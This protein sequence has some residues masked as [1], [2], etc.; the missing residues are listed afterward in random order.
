MSAAPRQP[1]SSRWRASKPPKPAPTR[2]AGQRLTGALVDTSFSPCLSVVVPVRNDAVR[3]QR[4]L[5]ALAG[6][7]FRDFE[8]IVIDDASDDD[9][10]HVAEAM[11]AH[12]VRLPQQSGSAAARNAGAEAA[13]GQI[14]L[15]VDSDVLVRHDTLQVA[16]DA[17]HDPQV[18]AVFGSYDLEPQ[19]PNLLS[20]YKNLAHR[21]YHQAMRGRATTFWTGCGAIRRGVFRAAGGFDAQRFVR[22]TIEDIELGVR[23]TN[24]GHVISHDKQ[25]QVTHLKRWTLW[26]IIKSDVFDRA[27]PWTRLTA[28]TRHVPNNLNLAKSQ[29]ASAVLSGALLAIYLAACWYLPWLIIAPI[30]VFLCIALSDRWTTRHRVTAPLRFVAGMAILGGLIWTA[31]YAQWWG[32]AMAVPLVGIVLINARFYSFF[33]RHRGLLF[34]AAVLPMHAL[35]YL[36]GGAVFVLGTIVFRTL[37]PTNSA[38]PPLLAKAPVARYRLYIALGALLYVVACGL[39]L[40]R[41]HVKQ[42]ALDF[43]VGDAIGFYV[44]LPSLV[45]DGDIQFQNQLETQFSGDIPSD[46]GAQVKKDGWAVGAAKNRWPIG[47]ALSVSPGFMLAHGLSHVLFA[48]TGA[49]ALQ[50]NGY[51]ILYQVSCVAIAMMIGT[52]SMI[53]ADRLLTERFGVD[54]WCA[55]AGVLSWWLGTNYLWFFVREPLVAHLIGASWIIFAVYLVHRIEQEARSGTLLWWQL[56]VL[57]LSFATALTCRFTNVL[58]FPLGVYVVVI[59]AKHRLLGRA[60]KQLPLILLALTPLILQAL[61]MQQF[62]GK[63][64]PD[65]AQELGYRRFERFYWTD[66][67]LLLSLFSSRRGLFFWTP[68]LLFSAWGLIWHTIGKRGWRDPLLL[69]L[70]AFALMLWYVNASWY[71]WH[72]GNSAGNRGFIELAA[73]FIIGFGLAYSWL[74]QLSAVPRRLVLCLIAFAM[75][76]NCTLLGLKLLGNLDGYGPLL[77][78]ESR[79]F[80]GRWERF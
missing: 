2:S 3:L 57:A 19:E 29:R 45:I 73:L 61:M 70:I 18:D 9:S 54:G 5:E 10:A 37:G 63:V 32:A 71:A 4:G 25:L 20:Q 16:V 38:A 56:P 27:I 80:T 49:E 36:Y 78:W 39:V 22:P 21:Y 48:F 13:R 55:A 12:V 11:G 44:Y 62:T 50:P 6:S 68:L 7:S 14:L 43:A 30:A 35:Y 26:S 40:A 52:A 33:A 51:S 76:V 31:W 66:P 79:L 64:V 77:S 8:V 46:F 65:S 28:Q 1:Q 67:A 41:A 74:A 34:S 24:A 69:S 59:L 47:V 60:L 72:F 17:M 58:V 75:L 42:T 53:V 15:F 23:L